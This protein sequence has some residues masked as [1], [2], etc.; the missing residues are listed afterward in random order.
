MVIGNVLDNDMSAVIGTNFT[1]SIKQSPWGSI[2]RYA[3]ETALVT[4]TSS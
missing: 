2:A 4:A 1:V 3:S